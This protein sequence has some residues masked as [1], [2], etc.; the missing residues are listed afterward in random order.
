MHKPLRLSEVGGAALL[1]NVE[2]LDVLVQC[3]S[4]IGCRLPTRY[5]RIA[6]GAVLVLRLGKLRLREGQ[7]LFDLRQCL[8]LGMQLMS[9][10]NVA[11]EREYEAA[12]SDQND[13]GRA[14]E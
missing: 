5:R 2:L 14:D 10:L 9:Q 4:P 8:C 3:E 11:N 7:L 13:K 1:R 6:R 12:A